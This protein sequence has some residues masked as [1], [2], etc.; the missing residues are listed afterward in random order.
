MV[1]TSRLLGIR[2]RVAPSVVLN[3][4]VAFFDV[5]IR[6]AVLAHRT[7]LDEVAIGLEFAQR[8][9]QIER[10]HDIVDLGENRMFAVDHRI[11]SRT[12]F[13][14]MHHSIRFKRLDERRQ[15]VILRHIA[16][17]KFDGLARQVLPDVQSLCQR[18]DR[19]KGL[20]PE[21]VVP[22]PAAKIVSNRNRMPFL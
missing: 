2:Y 15:K 13:G 11:R 21:F 8:E 19:R 16:D 4:D 22:L 18:T 12:L 3:G 1:K 7:Q 9:Q 17:K 6:S 5:D 10:P 14:K 20:H